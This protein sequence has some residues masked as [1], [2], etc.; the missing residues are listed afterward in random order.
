MDIKQQCLK[1]LSQNN[2]VEE[3]QLK[4]GQNYNYDGWDYINNPIPEYSY[5]NLFKDGEIAVTKNNRFSYVPAHT[6][7]FIEMNYVFKGKSSQH[8]NNELQ[9]LKE[10][11]LIILDHTMVHRIDYSGKDDLTV[12]ILIK[13]SGAVSKI[14]S[15]I[16]SKKN[17]VTNFLNQCTMPGKLGHSNYM[18]F[19]LKKS[20]VALNLANLI[21]YQG[22]T[23]SKKVELL[24]LL[25]SAM[26]E[27]L[28]NCLVKNYSDFA[29]RDQDLEEMIF[30]INSHCA[31]VTLQDLSEEF[32]YNP[33]Y[34]SNMIK[35]RTGKTFKELVELRRLD[36]AQNLII[37]TEL[38]LNEINEMIGYK[39]TTSLYRIFKK[40]LHQTP[41]AFRNEVRGAK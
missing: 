24:S 15:N 41:A 13:D 23:D 12:N 21:T 27:E 8:L 11:E 9:L 16:G 19:D 5:K 31:T 17:K 7:E 33:N 29:Q 14:L 34:I 10:G 35:E 4:Y 28:P 3:R 40:Y 30:Y 18:I 22:I 2:Y 26:F 38:S 32:S 1:I 36:T 39:D 6:H 37:K 25:T 20:P